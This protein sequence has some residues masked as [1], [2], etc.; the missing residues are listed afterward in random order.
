M[1][2]LLQPANRFF[3][4]LVPLAL[5]VSALSNN[6]ALLVGAQAE[7]LLG[8]GKRLLDTAVSLPASKNNSDVSWILGIGDI[9]GYGYAPRWL[10]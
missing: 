10:V 2:N 4:S 3:F 5:A 1:R 9:T 7:Y 8:L 6:E